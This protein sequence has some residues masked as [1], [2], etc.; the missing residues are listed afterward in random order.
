L[1]RELAVAG[2]DAERLSAF[3]APAGLDIGAVTPDEIALSILAEVIEVKRRGQRSVPAQ[4]AC[5]A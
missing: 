1:R 2:V 5:K 3:K 4:V